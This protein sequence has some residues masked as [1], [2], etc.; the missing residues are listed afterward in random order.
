M[1]GGSSD[2]VLCV[3]QRFC[4]EQTSLSHTLCSVAEKV[5]TGPVLRVPLAVLM[6]GAL[7]VIAVVNLPLDQALQTCNGSSMERD[8]TCQSIPYYMYCCVLGFIACSVFLR[9]SFELKILLLSA[10]FTVYN[11][12]IFH[13]HADLFKSH[14]PQGNSSTVGILR[15]PQRM[16]CFYLSLFFVTL[17]LLSRQ[18][19]GKPLAT[20]CVCHIW[21][22]V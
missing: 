17:V 10:A 9:M 15:D 2:D 3:W 18:V 5:E 16:S 6:I 7:L 8:I 13:T 20:A 21:V 4:N 11:V 22:C 1:A 12:I 14:R 19:S